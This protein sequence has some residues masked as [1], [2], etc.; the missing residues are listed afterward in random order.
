VHFLVEEGNGN[1]HA[2]GHA[3][4]VFLRRAMNGGVARRQGGLISSGT[5]FGSP[6][7]W[8]SRE[9]GPM[10]IEQESAVATHAHLRSFLEASRP[11]LG[12]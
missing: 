4:E 10:L 6:S 1:F 12:N 2:E 11:N 3:H 9:T 5:L 8:L 7:S